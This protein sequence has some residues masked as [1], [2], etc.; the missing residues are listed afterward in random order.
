MAPARGQSSRPGEQRGLQTNEGQRS[1]YLKF[2]F[3]LFFPLYIRAS[4][5]ALVRH[6]WDWDGHR[7]DLQMTADLTTLAVSGQTG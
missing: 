5:F 1:N 4:V 6:E 2:F 3:L 7:P